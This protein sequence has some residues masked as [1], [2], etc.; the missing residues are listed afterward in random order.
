MRRLI[1][2]RR[3]AGSSGRLIWVVPVIFIMG[4]LPKAADAQVSPG[5]DGPP[6]TDRERSLLERIQKLE[7]ELAQL[8]DVQ[9]RLAAIEA[10]LGE[11]S[12]K[13][14]AAASTGPS[15]PTQDPT[16]PLHPAAP[17]Q[18]SSTAASGS[19]TAGQSSATTPSNA[20]DKTFLPQASDGNPSI[21]GEFNPGRG[22]VVGRGRYG[23]LDLSG[24]MAVRYLNQLPPDQSAL[25]QVRHQA[26]QDRSKS[27]KTGLGDRRV[28]TTFAI[29]LKMVRQV[30][31]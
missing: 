30:D 18:S 14:D 29:E 19:P 31:A 8:R 15:A 26:R 23:E 4:A 12:T 25:A 28:Y 6:L 17:Q 13:P 21:F 2:T 1:G 20:D 24:Y 27:L 3:P 10:K 5:S 7:N 9:A 11:S 16:P 22:F